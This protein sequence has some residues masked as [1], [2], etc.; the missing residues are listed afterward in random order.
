RLRRLR[1]GLRRRQRLGRVQ[2]CLL[3]LR[4]FG[5]VGLRLVGRRTQLVER[6][7]L[8]FGR[9]TQVALL[10]LRG[11]LSGRRRRL[12]ELLLGGPVGNVLLH[13]GEVGRLGGGLLR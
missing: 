4:Q 7:F 13:L 11:G 2:Q 5:G 9:R 12:V 10:Q 3:L 8:L 1:R 6:L